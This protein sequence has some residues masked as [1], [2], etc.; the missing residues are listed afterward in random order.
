MTSWVLCACAH[1][2]TL[3]EIFRVIAAETVRAPW[4]YIVLRHVAIV[5]NAHI[6]VY[7]IA[8]VCISIM[9]SLHRIHYNVFVFNIG[10]GIIRFCYSFQWGNDARGPQMQKKES[11]NRTLPH[12]ALYTCWSAI[13]T[14]WFVS[15]SHC[16]VTATSWCTC[17]NIVS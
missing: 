1:K 8:I 2:N 17:D 16:I 6:V 3:A 15:Y 7:S 12:A 5:G 11:S 10:F 9:F 13:K 14:W 4:H